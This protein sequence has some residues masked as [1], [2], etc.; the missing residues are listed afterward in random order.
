M[1]NP[2]NENQMA[3]VQH[4]NY[5]SHP[6]HHPQHHTGQH[7]N[8]NNTQHTVHH[9]PYHSINGGHLVW[10]NNNSTGTTNLQQPQQQV[11]ISIPNVNMYPSYQQ[12]QAQQTQ[13]NPTMVIPSLNQLAFTSSVFPNTNNTTP[14]GMLY[15]QTNNTPTNSFSLPGLYGTSN[16]NTQLPTGYTSFVLPPP[17]VQ[18]PSY[19]TQILQQMMALGQSGQSL[20]QQFMQQTQPVQQTVK[21]ETQHAKTNNCEDTIVIV[22]DDEEVQIVDESLLHEQTGQGFQQHVGNRMLSGSRK[23]SRDDTERPVYKLSVHL[24]KTYKHI[25]NVYYAEKRKRE[26]LIQQQ[27]QQ[28]QQ[29]QL[30]LLQQ[31]Q[32]QQRQQQQFLLQQ[33]QYLQQQQLQQQ[34]H[35]HQLVPY[36][37]PVYNEGYDD[38]NG[39]YIAQINEELDGRYIVQEMMGKGSF[40]VVVKAF[41]R[42]NQEQ[43]AVKIIKN[44]QQFYNQA[45]IEIQI[46][47][48]LNSK[49]RHNKYNIVQ[50]KQHFQWRNHLCIVC[51]LLS[52]NLY[53]LLK[54]TSFRGV[55]LNLIRKFAQQLLYTLH[56]LSRP[57][58]SVI[59]CD[60]KPENILLK[61]HRKSVIKVIDFGS[62]CYVNKK[63]YKYIQSRFYRSPEVLLGLPYEPSIDMWS[64]GCILVE[65][66]TGLPLFD[67]KNE[68]DQI[69]KIIQV[70]GMPPQS[71]IERSPKKDRFFVWDNNTQSFRLANTSIKPASRSLQDII[72]VS[73]GG[74][75]GRR[76]NQS[77]HSYVDY[78]QFYDLVSRILQY[79]PS[80]RLLPIAGL[81]HDFFRLNGSTTTATQSGDLITTTTSSGRSSTMG[82]GDIASP[83]SPSIL[84]QQQPTNTNVQH[85]LNLQQHQLIMQQQSTMYYNNNGNTGGSG[86]GVYGGNSNSMFYHAPSSYYRAQI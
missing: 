85:Q 29:Q 82:N 50:F 46:L 76:L 64:F 56:F 57:E 32:Q 17:V 79:V 7:A 60:L 16:L 52:Y 27:Q 8:N 14:T 4:Y 69:H 47:Q 39:N 55:S 63:M 42:V 49:D 30:Q 40:G 84:T 2:N 80:N 19:N 11:S 33:Q 78:Q 74:P 15:Y 38:E 61:N 1:I 70:L 75:E 9:H 81:Q 45:K 48:D 58:V 54:Y 53:D 26:Q 20:Q 35:H 10:G 28:Q 59:H 22:D 37:Q 5:H 62:S 72:G 51:E 65:M 18:Q 66:H 34:H 43:V 67:G 44:K 23:I 41:D 86:S 83:L 71:M 13:Q 21:R 31:Q 3:K 68:L 24:L 77:G 6:Y 12:P 73:T 36:P 25:N